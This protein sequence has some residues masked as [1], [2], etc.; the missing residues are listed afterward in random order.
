MPSA[1]GARHE[2]GGQRR[3]GSGVGVEGDD[4]IGGGGQQPLLQRPRLARPS[5]RQRR[6][7]ARPGHRV[8]RR[9][10]GRVA[11]L[12]ST[13]I[14]SCTPGAPTMQV[15]QRA[16]PGGLVARRDHHRD[17][18]TVER[19]SRSGSHRRRRSGAHGP[20]ARV[21]PRPRSPERRTTPGG[22]ASAEPPSSVA[23]PLMIVGDHV[24]DDPGARHDERE[25]AA[26]DG[27]IRRRDT[28]RRP[29]HGWRAVRNAARIPS[30]DVP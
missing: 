3:V 22:R 26:R 18:S 30:D 13:T 19:A 12:S 10:G 1:L 14:T 25:T 16:D 4:P 23:V 6:A 24:G 29:A 9:L 7:G 15:E 2:C 17:R 20:G 21:R 5:G 8:V 28:A 27:S 11:R